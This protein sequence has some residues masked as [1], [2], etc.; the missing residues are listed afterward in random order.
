MVAVAVGETRGMLP[1]SAE[2]SKQASW[3]LREGSRPDGPAIMDQQMLLMLLEMLVINLRYKPE[4]FLG[5][6]VEFLAAQP[7]DLQIFI[8]Q[9][10]IE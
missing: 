7:F 6:G 5:G 10:I 3:V 4:R 8:H 2:L 1:V 9:L